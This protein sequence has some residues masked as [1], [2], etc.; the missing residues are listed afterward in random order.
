MA[1]AS[2]MGLVMT[3]TAL[4]CSTVN[5]PLITSVTGNVKGACVPPSRARAA[6]A[7]EPPAPVTSRGQPAPAV[8][9]LRALPPRPPRVIPP[10]A[11][12]LPLVRA[13][14]FLTAIGAVVFG[15]FVPTPWSVG[16]IALSFTGAALF[17]Y[18]KLKESG[19]LAAVGPAAAAGGGGA[20]SGSSGG[21]GAAPTAAAV[22]AEVGDVEKQQL[23]PQGGEGAATAASGVAPASSSGGAV[24]AQPL[25]AA[26]GAVSRGGGG[27]TAAAAAVRAAV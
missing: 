26:R 1:L 13:D 9:C 10:L 7:R 27:G 20:G 16:G 22:A 19:A 8:S 14:I 2:I 6:A 18:A 23:L 5:S 17:S 24:E 25:L 21:A 11:P 15:D 3:Y 4:L 12:S